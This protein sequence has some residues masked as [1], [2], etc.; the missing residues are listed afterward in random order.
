DRPEVADE[1]RTRGQGQRDG[2]TAEAGQERAPQEPAARREG[3]VAHG[4]ATATRRSSACG[5]EMDAQGGRYGNERGPEQDDAFH[6]D[7]LTTE[8]TV[9]AE[10]AR[11]GNGI[12]PKVQL[13]AADRWRLRAARAGVRPP[14]NTG[15]ERAMAVDA[16]LQT[17]LEQ[18]EEMGCL[19]LSAV[20]GFLQE[21]GLDDEQVEGFYEQLEERHIALTDDCARSEVADE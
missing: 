2:G 20:S 5:D 16:R 4:E 17:L 18:G 11:M 1:R 19:N 8:V 3:C 21:A 14:S 10:V 12:V 7:L 15:I 6:R 9:G 13:P